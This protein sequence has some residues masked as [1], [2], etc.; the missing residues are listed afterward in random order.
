MVRGGVRPGPA[1]VLREGGGGGGG[2]GLLL[3]RRAGGG[4]RAGRAAGR[5]G[6]ALHAPPPVGV[7]LSPRPPPASGPPTNGFTH[8]QTE[9]NEL[10]TGG[11]DF[12]GRAAAARVPPHRP[13]AG[14]AVGR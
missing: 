1:A 2:T 8:A 4:P 9:A 6:P 13:A 10:P 3:A 11:Q 14:R 12:S 5:A 7:P